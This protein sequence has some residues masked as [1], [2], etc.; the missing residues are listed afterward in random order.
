MARVAKRF[1]DFSLPAVVVNE[2]LEVQ[3]ASEEFIAEYGWHRTF[4]T[5]VDPG[6]Q[7][8]VAKFLKTLKRGEPLEISLHAKNGRLNFVDLFVTWNREECVCTIVQKSSQYSLVSSKLSALQVELTKRNEELIEEK[9]RVAGLLLDMQNLSAPAIVLRE[10]ISLVPIFGAMD[11][12]QMVSIFH[13]LLNHFIHENTSIAIIDFTASGEFDLIN[14]RGVDEFVKSAQIMGV[15]ILVSGL[16]PKQVKAL[17]ELEIQ[18]TDVQFFA[19][20]ASALV[21]IEKS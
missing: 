11:S 13:R 14:W 1:R 3:D 6:S 18:T 2:A 21:A 10:G 20:L 9:D 16:H 19:K 4:L 12:D 8:K 15:Q 7:S 5:V 17:N